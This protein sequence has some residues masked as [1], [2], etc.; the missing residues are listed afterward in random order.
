[1]TARIAPQKVLRAK[2]VWIYCPACDKRFNINALWSIWE[3]NWGVRAELNEAFTLKK[4]LHMCKGVRISDV[5]EG[6]YDD[7]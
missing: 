7:L 4:T 3:T 5:I 1:M 2:K 6:T